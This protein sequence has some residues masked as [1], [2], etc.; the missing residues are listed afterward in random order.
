MYL[1]MLT[2][3]GSRASAALRFFLGVL[4]GFLARGTLFLVL[5]P[6]AAERRVVVERHRE[7]EEGGRLEVRAVAGLER[8]REARPRNENG[9]SIVL[10]SILAAAVVRSL[11][12]RLDGGQVG[13]VRFVLVVDGWGLGLVRFRSLREW[14]ETENLGQGQ[15]PRELLC[16]SSFSAGRSSKYRGINAFRTRLAERQF[17]SAV[18]ASRCSRRRKIEEKLRSEAGRDGAAGLVVIGGCRLARQGS[19]RATPHGRATKFNV[20]LGGVDRQARQGEFDGVMS[21]DLVPAQGAGCYYFFPWLPRCHGTFMK[22][23]GSPARLLPS[24]GSTEIGGR[25]PGSK[26]PTSHPSR[27]HSY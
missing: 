9:R 24:V 18:P 20:E 7:E 10:V 11:G 12:G 27:H 23:A 5:P 1:S 6:L 13:T 21:T 8:R 22:I 4:A 17:N 14:T 3:L 26:S 16:S 15:Q 25:F 19:S 2:I